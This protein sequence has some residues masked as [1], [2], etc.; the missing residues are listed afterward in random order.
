MAYIRRL[1]MVGFSTALAI[2]AGCGGSSSNTGETSKEGGAEGTDSGGDVA[3]PQEASSGNDGAGPA[4][5]G[6][7]GDS[8]QP[9]ADGGAIGT[10]ACGTGASCTAPAQ[11]CCGVAAHGDAGASAS[12]VAAGSCGH[13]ISISCEGTDNCS[14]GDKCCLAGGNGSSS[15][16][17]EPSCTGAQI[18]DKQSDCSP[19]ET[20]RPIPELGGIGLCEMTPVD[21]GGG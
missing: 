19:S 11:V 9:V 13:G 7:G 3:A 15:T 18:C 20:C 17:C 4:D 16:T 5:G 12:C 1:V 2:A 21:A 8:S 10:I 6:S 14:A